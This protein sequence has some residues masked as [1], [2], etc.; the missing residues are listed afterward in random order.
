MPQH[1]LIIDEDAFACLMI[2]TGLMKLD[3]E[4]AT[5][6]SLSEAE[7]LI[8]LKSFDLVIMDIQF[9]DGQG[10]QFCTKLHEANSRLPIIF[11]TDRDNL[12]MRA[13]AEE[14][15]CVGFIN[16]RDFESLKKCVG[17]IMAPGPR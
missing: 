10:I 13:K 7:A 14:A 15:G 5:A 2:S 9:R 8:H 1:L 4:I 16:K 11:Y 12:A 6:L 17:A 3:R